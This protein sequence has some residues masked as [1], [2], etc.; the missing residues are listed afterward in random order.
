MN[1]ID[2][3]CG[4]QK[5]A[6]V[7]GAAG[8]VGGEVAHALIA[9]GWRVR[10][11]ARRP[12]DAKRRAAWV[13]AVE[14][15]AG[16]AMNEADV[17]AAASGAS[18]IFHGANPPM[19][20][21][22]RGL[23]IPMLRN[24]IAAARMSGARL[25]F[26]GNV[27]NFGPDA[28]AFVAE[29]APQRPLTRKGAV[30]VEME[31]MLEA[32]AKDGVRSL[33]LR[34]G[35]YFGPHQPNSWFRDAMVKP[36]APLRSVTYPGER[37]VGHAFAYLPDVAE[38]VARLAAIEAALPAFEV[39]HFDGHWLPR[40]VEIAEAVRRVCG[41]PDLPIHRF[42]WALLYIGALFSTFFR[43][44][45]EMRYLWR[46]PLRLDHARLASLIG[47]EPHTPL[48]A[49]LRRTLTE[50]G[51][52]PDAPPLAPGGVADGRAAA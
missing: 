21:N 52:L 38:T 27:Y 7:I 45:L 25:I 46:I 33:I 34:S 48:D 17:T 43:E 14:W 15:V 37:E 31:A 4:T 47:A 16:D 3:P 5:T 19:Y 20:R 11:L 1:P 9:H 35:D 12:E 40:G 51:C 44:A 6:L 49:A 28:G 32:A 50:L 2:P 39:M 24:A 22:W 36:G 8:G 10:G 13:G 23:A 41:R 42:P 26:P 30:R 18:V 29:T